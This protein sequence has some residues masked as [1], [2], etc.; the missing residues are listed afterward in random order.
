[1]KRAFCRLTAADVGVVVLICASLVLLVS[2]AGLYARGR[3]ADVLCMANLR[4]LLQGWTLYHED[5]DGCLVGGSPYYTGRRTPY[6]WVEVPLFNAT[7]NPGAPPEGSGSPVPSSSQYTQEYRLNGIRAGKLFPYT[8]NEKL[9]HCP[10]DLYWKTRPPETASYRSYTVA[11][12]MNSEDF[13]HTGRVGWPGYV[14]ETGWRSVQMPDGTAK[15][16]QL[17]QKWQDISSPSRKCVFVEEDDAQHGASFPGGGFVLMGQGYWSWWDVPAYYHGD[18]SVLG[19]ADGRA[20]LHRWTD[21]RTLYLMRYQ[22]DPAT[23]VIPGPVQPN[24]PDLDFM[25]QGYMACD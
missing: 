19:F 20:D 15:V 22:P 5:H 23:G 3:E 17:A 25:C 6:R 4:G 16:L 10:N 1:M 12:L 24:N 14:P 7:D 13:N 11:G 21:S 8:G 2:S 9:Y 18:R